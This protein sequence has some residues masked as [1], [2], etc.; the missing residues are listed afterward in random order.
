MRTNKS[1]KQL[2]LIALF[3][4]GLS[5]CTDKDD[6][7]TFGNLQLLFTHQVDNNPLELNNSTYGRV[8]DCKGLIILLPYGHR[9]FESDWVQNN[10]CLTHFDY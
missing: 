10:D 8:V 5:S 1:L 4:I 3:V 6:N 9:R 7:P 2:L